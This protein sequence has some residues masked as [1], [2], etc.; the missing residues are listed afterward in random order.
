M[1]KILIYYIIR[2]RNWRRIGSSYFLD[3]LLWWV[4]LFIPELVIY[5]VFFI[6]IF[7][8]V[9]FFYVDVAMRSVSPVDSLV[10]N[11][12]GYYNNFHL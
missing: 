3:Y 12:F 9:L 7:F 10:E 11:N 8:L 2:C 6:G 5:T 4:R 1:I